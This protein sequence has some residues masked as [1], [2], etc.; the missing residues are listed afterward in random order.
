V[1]LDGGGGGRQP[2]DVLGSG[3]CAHAVG[4]LL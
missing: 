2:L 3:A 1:D 4:S